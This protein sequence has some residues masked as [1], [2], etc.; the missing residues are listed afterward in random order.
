MIHKELIGFFA[1]IF[2]AVVLL[3]VLNNLKERIMGE[4]LTKSDVE[5]IQAE[6]DDRKYNKRKELIAEVKETRAQGDLSENFEYHEAKH[7]KNKNEGRIR[8]LERMLNT[9]TIIDDTSKD[10]VVSINNTVTVY[11]PE[12]DLEESYKLVTSIRA[13]SMDGK[14]AIDSPVGKALLGHK[15][16]DTVTVHVNDEISYPLEIKAIDQST[17]DS[18]D[19]ISSY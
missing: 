9:A 3:C 10:G 19:E 16:G 11:F 6:I 7:A 14:I 15:V 5:K 17:D 4:M 18:G 1:V 8:Y 13:N 12:D 2:R